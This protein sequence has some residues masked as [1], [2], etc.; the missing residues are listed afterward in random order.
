MAGLDAAGPARFG[1]SLSCQRP[2]A[3]PEDDEAR[4]LSPGVRDDEGGARQTVRGATTPPG[5][6]AGRLGGACAQIGR[7]AAGDGVEGLIEG[8]VKQRS[9]RHPLSAPW[10]YHLGFTAATRIPKSI[11]YSGVA[12]CLGIATYL[13]CAPPVRTVRSNLARV[14]PHASDHDGPTRQADLSELCRVPRR[15][16]PVPLGPTGKF[17][18]RHPGPGGGRESEGRS[19][20]GVG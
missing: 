16:R 17:R 20:P 5:G 4:G 13:S 1:D 8:P 3:N 14:F 18:R 10:F 15:L 11:L 7:P 2:L 19:R 12:D 9:F 6:G